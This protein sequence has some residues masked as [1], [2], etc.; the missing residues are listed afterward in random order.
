MEYD[1]VKTEFSQIGN[2]VNQRE[3][4]YFTKDFFSGE[5]DRLYSPNLLSKLNSKLNV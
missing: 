4:W 1:F 2:V 5:K 3:G